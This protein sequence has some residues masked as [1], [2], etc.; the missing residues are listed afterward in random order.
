MLTKS[1]AIIS[2]SIHDLGDAMSIGV[3]YVLEKKSKQAP[4]DKYTYGYV[5]F[6]VI[7]GL[8]TIIIL[9]VGSVIVIV[10][11]VQR[12][13]N[14]VEINYSGMI[15]LSIAGIVLNFLAAFFTRE[16]DSIN[17]KAVNLHM[18]ED[19]LGWVVVLI[20]AIV[21]RFTDISIIDP[22]MS[23]G[24]ATFI[25]I[26]S[27]KELKSIVDLFLVKIPKDISVDEIR[28]HVME[29]DG[30]LNVHHIHIWSMDGYNKYATM[31]VVT[32][33]NP[34]RIKQ[35]IRKELGEHGIG[36]V[37]LEI[38]S[39]SEDCEE[40]CCNPVDSHHEAGHHHH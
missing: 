18:F 16:G 1:V 34:V 5:R 13:I 15:I 11:A 24:V 6:S 30:V 29:I 2:D 35:E 19:V 27:L 38:E 31:H 36:H 17:Q 12:I 23:I 8:I 9:M 3:S 33:E 28:K 22:I 26:H 14:P 7:G 4:D 25:A 40:K 21:M 32:D 39:S 37:T 10:N 20:G